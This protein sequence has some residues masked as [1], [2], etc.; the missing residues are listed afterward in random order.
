[1]LVLTRKHGEKIVIGDN[2]VL[3]VLEIRGDRVRLGV[4]APSTVSV[5]REEVLKKINEA[6]DNKQA[7]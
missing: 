5:H 2:I 7:Q 1:M 4:S 6:R 3:T